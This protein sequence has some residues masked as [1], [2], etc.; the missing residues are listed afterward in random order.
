[1]KAILK[2]EKTLEYCEECIFCRWEIDNCDNLGWHCSHPDIKR[3]LILCKEDY[4]NSSKE[5]KHT[6]I[7]MWCPI[8]DPKTVVCPDC[9][10]PA[11]DFFCKKCGMLDDRGT[12]IQLRKRELK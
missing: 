10:E 7:P 2:I 11:P 6:F 3:G 9:K 5:Y 12:L 8:V 4:D 1:M